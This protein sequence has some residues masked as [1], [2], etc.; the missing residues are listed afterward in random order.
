MVCRATPRVT[1]ERWPVPPTEQDPPEYGLAA[2]VWTGLVF[3]IGLGIAWFGV[4]L[5]F[6]FR[7]GWQLAERLIP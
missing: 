4:A 2:C 5:G 3:L 6:G 7:F 1:E